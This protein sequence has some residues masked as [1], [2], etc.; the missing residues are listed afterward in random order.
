[1]EGVGA[2]PPA[3]QVAVT[4]DRRIALIGV[5]VPLRLEGEGVSG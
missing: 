4:M 1:M 5:A 2:R 3:T